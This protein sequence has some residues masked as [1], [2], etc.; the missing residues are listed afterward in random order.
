M[1]GERPQVPADPEHV[2]I[3][4]SLNTQRFRR[5]KEEQRE[6][7]NDANFEHAVE[8]SRQCTTTEE[9]GC[10]LMSAERQNL[11]KLNDQRQAEV[12]ARKQARLVQNDVSRLWLAFLRGQR[13]AAMLHRPMRQARAERR[14]RM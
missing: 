9:A 10:P 7:I 14:A 13:P 11:L 5:L 3:L 6:F 4:A 8:I 1:W 12:D 2:A